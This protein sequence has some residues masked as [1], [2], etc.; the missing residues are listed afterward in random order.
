MTSRVLQ[1][2]SRWNWSTEKDSGRSLDRGPDFG[3][4]LEIHRGKD[5]LSFYFGMGWC[6]RSV[7]ATFP[8]D[9]PRLQRLVAAVGGQV[10][11]QESSTCGLRLLPA[12]LVSRDG[13]RSEVSEGPHRAC[14]AG[15]DALPRRRCHGA[16]D[17]AVPR[18]RPGRLKEFPFPPSLGG[19][20]SFG[21]PDPVGK[22]Y[23]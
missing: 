10:G 23:G 16:V 22:S 6:F 4:L 1:E 9:R 18:S 19:D 14:V 12:S 5:F 2:S 15:R 11:G 21:F 17:G 13:P 7:P 8:P 3:H 20:R